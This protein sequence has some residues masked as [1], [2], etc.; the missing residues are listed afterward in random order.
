MW[1][2]VFGLGTTVG[3]LIFGN[4][5]FLGSDKCCCFAWEDRASQNLWLSPKF[6][7]RWCY[8]FLFGTKRKWQNFGRGLLVWALLYP[9]KWLWVCSGMKYI[10]ICMTVAIVCCCSCCD[11]LLLRFLRLATWL[12][13]NLHLRHMQLLP[14]NVA[15]LGRFTLCNYLRSF[16]HIPIK[17]RAYRII[18]NISW[19]SYDILSNSIDR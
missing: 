17:S 4:P 6:Q 8:V 10:R 3:R 7:S 1:S 2:W 16:H 12:L 14:V 15:R 5:S 13:A 18:N 9:D 11:E 19:Y